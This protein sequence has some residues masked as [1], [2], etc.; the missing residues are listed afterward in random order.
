MLTDHGAKLK[1]LEQSIASAAQS[2]AT[3]IGE[4]EP[5]STRLDEHGGSLKR[6]PALGHNYIGHNCVGHNCVG[7]N[8]IGHNYIGPN[9]INHNYVGPQ[10]CGP[11]LYR[12]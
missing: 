7:H 11:Y 8:Y 9:Y 6:R 3:A 1:E 5:M 12:P 2:V 4:L 10:L